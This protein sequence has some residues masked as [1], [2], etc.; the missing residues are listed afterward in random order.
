M[1]QKKASYSIYVAWWGVGKR[2][3]LF[4]FLRAGA[5]EGKEPSAL[6]NYGSTVGVVL[7]FLD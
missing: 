2:S 1:Q 6:A 7:M 5:H 4:G 3:R